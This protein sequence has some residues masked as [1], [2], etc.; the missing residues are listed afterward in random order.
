[1]PYYTIE[2]LVKKMQAQRQKEG[3]GSPTRAKGPVWQEAYNHITIPAC[4]QWSAFELSLREIAALRVGDV[5]E[6]PA[7][8]IDRTELVLAGVPK[9]TGK[10]GLEGDRVAVQLTRKITNPQSL[11]PHVKFV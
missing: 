11:S 4:A 5:L 6:M 7:T 10:V 9:F 2:P 3:T 1:M 8:L